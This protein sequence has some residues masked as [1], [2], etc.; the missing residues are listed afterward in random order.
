MTL[1]FGL[2]GR[3]IGYTLSPYIHNTVF[4]M[5]NIDA[6][7]HVIDVPESELEEKL[8]YIFERY[9]GLNVTIP[10]KITIMKY[11]DELT[12]EAEIVGAVNTVKIDNKKIGHNTDI[13]GIELSLKRKNIDVK[14]RDCLV[15]GAG[16]AARAAVYVF[17]KGE[18]RRVV[19]CNRS[20]S[21]AE[22]LK[23]HF[24]KYDIDVEIVDWD[25]RN[26][27]ARQSDIIINCTPVGTL[28][29]ESPLD[30][31]VIDSGKVV[32]DMVY[33]PRYTRLLRDAASRGAVIVDGLTILIY[34]ALAADKFWLGIEPSEELFNAVERVLEDL[35][36]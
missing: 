13:V 20:R 19:V 2:L 7:Y 18:A 6:E 15:L 10:Y 5:Y 24:E 8:K 22:E 35:A 17:Y 33:R 26:E 21:R 30:T 4:K 3:N 36:W 12:R 9:T 25:K 34:Q 31:T 29:E 16:G 11:L 28:S 32:I 27:I 23:K 14:G 1:L